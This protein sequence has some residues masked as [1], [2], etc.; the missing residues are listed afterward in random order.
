MSA[1]ETCRCCGG[2]ASGKI[3][4]LELGRWVPWCARC[5]ENSRNLCRLYDS[6]GEPDLVGMPVVR[7][8][9]E[10][11]ESVRRRIGL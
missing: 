1:P 7:C 3:E 9:D 6:E 4:V 5:V 8:S 10:I 11:P 2:N